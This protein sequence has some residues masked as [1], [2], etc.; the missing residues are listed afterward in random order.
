[1][2]IKRY[3]VTAA[4]YE[5]KTPEV[6]AVCKT[7]DEA[8]NFTLEDMRE[9]ADRHANEGM[10]LEDE[11]LRV[12]DDDSIDGCEWN[13]EDVEIEIEDDDL[14]EFHDKAYNEGY[15][16]GVAETEAGEDF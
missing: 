14:I 8:K 1:M 16:D 5:S 15:R 2:K 3:V 12:A 13:I 4:D 11:Y 7:E 6:R 10:V 9:Y